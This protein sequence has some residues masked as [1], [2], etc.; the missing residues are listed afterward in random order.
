M[1]EGLRERRG[2]PQQM[3]TDD[4]TELSSRLVDPWAFERGVGLHF[5]TPG[6]PTENAFMESFHGKFRDE[7]L[8]RAFV[9]LTLSK[10]RIAPAFGKR[11][12]CPGT[13]CYTPLVKP[14]GR[15]WASREPMPSR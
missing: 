8:V 11:L 5:I 6:E 3:V 14:S 1:L 7:C 9:N 13:L 4:G 10:S 2:Q 12:S 15:Y